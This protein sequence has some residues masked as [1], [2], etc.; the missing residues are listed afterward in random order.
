MGRGGWERRARG[1]PTKPFL[2]SPLR[3]TLET[4]SARVPRPRTDGSHGLWLHRALPLS[5][6]HRWDLQGLPPQPPLGRGK[7]GA[8]RGRGLMSFAAPSSRCNPPLWPLHREG[9]C[10]LQSFGTLGTTVSNAARPRMLFD[11]ARQICNCPQGAVI[12]S[13][14]SRRR[15]N[16]GIS[17]VACPNGTNPA[18]ILHVA[19][20]HPAVGNGVLRVGLPSL[21][22]RAWSQ[23]FPS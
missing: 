23:K 10:A 16:R 12:V 18:S 6:Q 4:A 5:R 3:Q 9:A 21:P 20:W 14:P 11:C 17:R 13:G 2:P 7:P 19:A 22:R 8:P 15:I 1:A